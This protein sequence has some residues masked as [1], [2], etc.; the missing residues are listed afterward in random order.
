TLD[1]EPVAQA[2]KTAAYAV[3]HEAPVVLPADPGD[4]GE[5]VLLRRE[6]P[7]CTDHRFGEEGRHTL[8][9]HTQDLGLHRGRR[10]VGDHRCLLNEFTEPGSETLHADDA[11]PKTVETVVATGPT[12]QMGLVRP[13]HGEPVTSRQLCGRVDGLASPAGQNHLRVGHGSMCGQ[14]LAQ[15]HGGRVGEVTVDG[16]GVQGPDLAVD[17]IGDLGAAVP[18]VAVPKA[19]RTVQEAVAGIVPEPHTFGAGHHELG[20]LGHCVHVAK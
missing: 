3:L 11:G 2:G 1:A 4:L 8:R 15:L 14:T 20:P 18:D 5:V 12:D 19:G 6:D 7:T 10:P 16:V 13:S 9:T 17:R